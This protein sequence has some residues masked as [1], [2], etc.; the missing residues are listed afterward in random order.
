MDRRV[1]GWLLAQGWAPNVVKM[2]LLLVKLTVIGILLYTAFWLTVLFTVVAISGAW[3]ARS[4]EQA[5]AE[6]CVLG[7]GN[8]ADHK[9]SVFY[10]P[11]N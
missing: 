3:A 6:E 2:V 1:Q 7:D 11:I 4:S 9:Q 5:D 8:Q 10:D